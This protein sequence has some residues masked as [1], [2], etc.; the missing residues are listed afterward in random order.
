MKRNFDW[1]SKLKGIFSFNTTPVGVHTI[2]NVRHPRTQKDPDRPTMNVTSDLGC[3][4]I[5]CVQYKNGVV[6][7]GRDEKLALQDFNGTG[8]LLPNWK[9]Y[10]KWT[11]ADTPDG[12]VITS[13]AK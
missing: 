4:P 7:S 9:D 2:K 11:I 1:W 12:R 6:A 8:D 3:F 10:P 13:V 5:F